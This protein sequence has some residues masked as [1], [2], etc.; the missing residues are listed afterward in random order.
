MRTRPPSTRL[1][2]QT[3]PPI[4]ALRVSL[5]PPWYRAQYSEWLAAL[6]DFDRNVQASTQAFRDTPAGAFALRMFAE[7]R[8]RVVGANPELQT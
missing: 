2:A 7:E 1:T 5:H 8:W 6:D 3:W 4:R